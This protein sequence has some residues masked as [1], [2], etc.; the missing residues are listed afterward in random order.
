LGTGNFTRIVKAEHKETGEV[1]A[2]KVVEKKQVRGEKRG[3][4]R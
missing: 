3:K 2:V 1:F 4:G